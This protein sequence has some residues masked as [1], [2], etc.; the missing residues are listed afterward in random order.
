MTRKKAT[1]P[2]HICGATCTTENNVSQ[3]RAAEDGAKLTSTPLLGRIPSSS[4]SIQSPR[5]TWRHRAGEHN[6]TL[7]KSI[8]QYNLRIRITLNH[9]TRYSE[10][11][12]PRS[13]LTIQTQCRIVWALI[14]LPSPYTRYLLGTSSQS[15]TVVGQRR[16]CIDISNASSLVAEESGQGTG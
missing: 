1:G 3:V 12:Q 6:K 7:H 8:V 15:V 11:Q 10:I 9:P 13:L 2:S 16:L 14:N 5:F 4:G